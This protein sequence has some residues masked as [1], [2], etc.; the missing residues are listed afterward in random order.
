MYKGKMQLGE[1]YGDLIVIGLIPGGNH[2]KA[3]V[4]CSCGVTKEIF[5]TS[6]RSGDSTSCGCKRIEK[7]STHGMSQKNLHIYRCWT[8]LRNRCDNPNNPAYP[9]YGAR[10]INYCPEWESFENFRDWAYA[11]GYKP[12]LEIDRE[13]NDKGYSPDNCRWATRTT[14]Q[15]NRRGQRNSASQY[16]GVS[17]SKR[18]GNWQASI[19]H[20]GKSVHLGYFNSEIEA[21]KARDNYIH[22]NGLK[23]FTLNFRK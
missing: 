1:V 19:K 9:D 15:R 11:N 22:I 21:A 5:R 6:L 13:D 8:A 23:N 7:V 10:G 4:K 17:R 20:D 12:E 2:P 14:Q 16:V 18:T 3:L